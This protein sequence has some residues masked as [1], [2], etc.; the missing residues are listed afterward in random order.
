[1]LSFIDTENGGISFKRLSFYLKTC[2]VPSLFRAV[3]KRVTFKID[4]YS[5][6]RITKALLVI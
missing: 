5:L 4:K 3:I 6:C 1:M 2:R